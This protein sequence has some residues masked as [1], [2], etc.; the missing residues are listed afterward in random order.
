MACVPGGC[1]A[2]AEM[3]DKN[4]AEDIQLEEEELRE[5]TAVLGKNVRKNPGMV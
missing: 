1:H 2:A 5:W 4:V 3:G